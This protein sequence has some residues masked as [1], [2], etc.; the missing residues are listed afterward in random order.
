MTE[1][2]NEIQQCVKAFFDKSLQNGR[3]LIAIIDSLKSG[4]LPEDLL[5]SEGPGLTE[6]NIRRHG[7]LVGTKYLIRQYNEQSAQIPNFDLLAIADDEDR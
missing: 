3:S 1:N 4:P 5:N 6:S 7:Q 2:F